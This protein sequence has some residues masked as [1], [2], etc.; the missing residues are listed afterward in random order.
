MHA[1][2]TFNIGDHVQ[3]KRWNDGMTHGVVVFNRGEHDP[4]RPAVRYVKGQTIVSSA[5]D[6]TA[7]TPEEIEALP[8]AED[9]ADLV[10]QTV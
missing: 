7:L 1:S 5:S 8:L 9:E 6:L 3:A 4:C 2:P 10:A